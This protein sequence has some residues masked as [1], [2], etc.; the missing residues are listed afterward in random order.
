MNTLLKTLKEQARR[1]VLERNIIIA[2]RA[3]SGERVQKI[4]D[5]YGLS[6]A[7]I[8][9]IVRRHEQNLERSRDLTTES[10]PGGAL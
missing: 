1:G 4:A 8:Y 2:R 7:A 10:K 6:R 9:Q 5:E 3:L